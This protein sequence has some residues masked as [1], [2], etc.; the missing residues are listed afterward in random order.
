MLDGSPEASSMP[1][2]RD[3]ANRRA[4]EWSSLFFNRHEK[5]ASRRPV[6]ADLVLLGLAAI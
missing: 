4:A 6:L 3:V 1:Q 5:A 2:R